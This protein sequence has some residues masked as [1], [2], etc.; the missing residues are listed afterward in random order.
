MENIS[1]LDYVSLPIYLIVIYFI[2]YF[3]R[4]RHYPKNHPWRRYFM[5]GLS[6]KIIGA[7]VNGLI[8]HYYYGGGDTFNFFY[9]SRMINTALD[10]SF[11][12]W[13][14]L[15]FHLP[16]QYDVSYYR[17][18]SQLWWYQDS[19]SYTVA[20]IG[21]F[22]GVFTF[23][24]YLPTAAIFAFISYS[25]SWAMFRTFAKIYPH[26]T[27]QIAVAF[28]FIP[29][30]VL[31]GSAVYKDTVCMFALGW[32]TYATFRFMIQRDFGVQNIILAVAS[33]ILVAK[34]KVY[35]LISFLPAL[36]LWIL[37]NYLQRIQSH[38]IRRT[39]KLTTIGAFLGISV[40]LMSIYGEKLGA[41]SLENIADK[42]N[43]TRMW[44]TYA[45]ET[46]D[47]STYSLGEFDGTSI[48]GMI[49]K[50]PQAVN[51]SL[52]RPYLWEAKKV[53][54]LF[55]ALEALLFLIITLHVLIKIGMKR[56]WKAIGTDPTIQFCLI[57]AVVFA[58]AVGITTYN[59][60]S[61]SRYK[62]PCLPFYALA[63]ILIYYRYK[64]AK[65]K[66]LP[67]LF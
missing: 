20:A 46:T 13:L 53:I 36:G 5:I 56:T 47:G 32:M 44:I 59:F 66:I 9:H 24:T 7:V 8:H 51:V 22:V 50:F 54:M 19:S 60:G 33:F 43:E 67:P 40:F 4:N 58:F 27:K 37:L 21:A 25:G 17:Y 63:I 15:L 35:I 64:P 62:I 3:I 31:W 14:N 55:S 16:D 48:S 52:F 30:T 18:T 38:I 49:S 45:S 41:Y 34:V 23:N 65:E 29:T 2:A 61:L 1:L 10:E 6:V 11:L 26:L 57:F 39:V 28:L 42:A 12:K